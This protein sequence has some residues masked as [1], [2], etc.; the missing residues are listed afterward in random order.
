MEDRVDLPCPGDFKFIC[1]GGKHLYYG[2]GTFLFRCKFQ[3]C[4][5]LF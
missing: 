5:L 4:Y 3:V 1:N 2:K